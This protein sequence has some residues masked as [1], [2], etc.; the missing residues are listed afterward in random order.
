M[1]ASRAEHHFVPR[2][3]LRN[4]ATRKDGGAVRLFQ[5]SAGRHVAQASIKGQCA[6]RHLYGQDGSIEDAFVELEGV[7][8]SVI[9]GMTVDEQVPP[10]VTVPLVSFLIF[11]VLQESRTVS[12]AERYNAA[13]TK[14]MRAHLASDPAAP[15]ELLPYLDSLHVSYGDQAVVLALRNA[16]DSVPVV[17]DL[18]LKLLKNGTPVEFI[19]SD[20]PVVLHNHWARRFPGNGVLG[21]ASSGLQIFFPLSP[22]YLAVLYDTDVY[23]LGG[24]DEDVILLDDVEGIRSLNALQGASARDNL[25]YASEFMCAEIDSMSLPSPKL[26][27]EAIAVATVPDPRDGGTFIIQSRRLLDAELVLPLIQVRD[28]VRAVPHAKRRR[29]RPEAAA[30]ADLARQETDAKPKA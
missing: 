3:Y 22:A 23:K 16:V 5:I 11:I 26:S 17:F 6:R 14:I 4:F 20:S 24:Y 8:A 30:I 15:P 25:Y 13:Q 29:L 2:F 18:R 28:D 7:A 12:A 9:R 21:L 10:P 19:T 27:E 1:G